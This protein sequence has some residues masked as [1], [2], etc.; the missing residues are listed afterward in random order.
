MDELVNIP[1][2]LYSSDG[3]TEFEFW[4]V[5]LVYALL[6]LRFLVGKSARLHQELGKSWTLRCLAISNEEF[7]RKTSRAKDIVTVLKPTQVGEA[8][9]LRCTRESSLRNSAKQRP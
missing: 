1:A 4:S 8:R 3:E 7:P 5:L 2:L 6:G 9:R